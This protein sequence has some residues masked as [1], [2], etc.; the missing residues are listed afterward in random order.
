MTLVSL[1]PCWAVAAAMATSSP[2][3]PQQ[4]GQPP[5]QEQVCDLCQA[6]FSSRNQLFRHLR[7][8]HAD[9]EGIHSFLSSPSPLQVLQS[10]PKERT[11]AALAA[12]STYWGKNPVQDLYYNAQVEAGAFSREEWETA[13]QVFATPLPVT[14]RWLE[15]STTSSVN[16]DIRQEWFHQLQSLV[17]PSSL[18]SS[19]IIDPQTVQIAV[20]PPR[21]WSP[22]AQQVLMDAQEVG[23][24]NRQELCSMIPPFLLLQ[25]DFVTRLKQENKVQQSNTSHSNVHAANRGFAILDLC[26]APGSKSL[27]LLDMMQEQN[28]EHANSAKSTTSAPDNAGLLVCNDA[29]IPRL[30]T[31]ARRSRRQPAYYR[32]SMIL[33]SSDGRFFPALRR[34]GGY[35]HKFDAV[36]VDVPCSGDGTL[37]K[38]SANQWQQWNVQ[39]H[40]A[41]HKLQVKLLQR[42]LQSVTKGGRVVYS[43]CSLDPIENEAVLV[44]AIARMGGP[45]AY[46]I[47]PLPTHL[48]PRSTESLP[49]SKGATTWI[50]P[51]PQFGKTKK[52]KQKTKDL[53]GD[54]DDTT[55]AT[56]TT[57]TTDS[58]SMK[59]PTYET[60]ESIDQVPSQFFQKKTILPSMFPP[61]ARTELVYQKAISSMPIY[62]RNN[63]N[64]DDDDHDEV[65][66][67][68]Q[69]LQQGRFFG[70]I[71][72]DEEMQQFE[73]MLPNCG[74]ILP[75]HLDSGGFFCALIERMPP[76]YYPICCPLQR[77]PQTNTNAPPTISAT[78]QA[79]DGAASTIVCN[80]TMDETPSSISS[81]EQY[82]S[83]SPPTQSNYHGRI[84]FPVESGRQV[85]ELLAKDK[86]QGAEVYFEGVATKDMA[87]QWLQKHRAY[88]PGISEELLAPPPSLTG[89]SDDENDGSDVDAD[90]QDVSM[91][92]KR[93]YINDPNR[94][95]LYTPLFPAPHPNLVAEFME[96]FGLQSDP[97]QAKNLGVDV[98]P[99]HRL[100]VTAGASGEEDA[101]MVET[102]LD[103][104]DA[105]TIVRRDGTIVS[106][107]SIPG[108]DANNGGGEK[109]GTA[110][111]D[112]NNTKDNKLNSSTEKPLRKVHRRRR[113]LQLA[114]VSDHIKTL[115]KGGAKFNPMEVGL[116]LCWVPI[117]GYCRDYT[118]T[119]PRSKS[120]PSLPGGDG[121]AK[122]EDA[123]SRA[124]ES[125][126]FGLL[127]EAAE[128]LGR[129]VTR[130]VVGLTQEEAC[131]LLEISY[132]DIPTGSDRQEEAIP[133][134][135]PRSVTDWRSRWGKQRLADLD[136]WG[137]GATIGVVIGGKVDSAGGESVFP[138]LFLPC[139]LTKAKEKGPCRL[140]LLAEQRLSDCWKRLLKSMTEGG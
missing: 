75:Q 78:P 67:M 41:L 92:V 87:I 130:R 70:E 137:P 55:I 89:K 26:A 121:A 14:F 77:E 128:F 103:S 112:G 91:N 33:N 93:K 90:V 50:V 36:L 124:I 114:L 35:K 116:A 99:V 31:V 40:L 37:R 7:D 11:A 140:E 13:K 74:R 4:Q 123:T 18:Q 54:N 20:Q 47:L 122:F 25:P 80:Q 23:V 115:Y 127:D 29:S 38:M 84:L 51:H 43:T 19:S 27:Q 136:K 133:S 15:S 109:S 125:G 110:I 102:C 57:A 107:D 82:E 10:D 139:V 46:R 34:W 106:P 118:D 62:K 28:Y 126:R 65:H 83:S 60:F 5:Q 30:L 66:I 1:S 73:A 58:S 32:P 132:L 95:T 69:K 135:L 76:V 53:D 9:D 129:C 131:K 61:R 21:Q 100:I 12:R 85:R 16:G 48:S 63:D 113:F 22:Q 17:P 96:F 59:E 52:S 44:T 101:V 119:Q 72:S 117:P 49:Y 39:E 134:S 81:R 98:F 97:K 104:D 120:D 86:A 2:P 24:A 94:S 3:Q 88:L 56:A 111:T 64:D 105:F 68:E 6:A 138:T 71:L 8:A 79:A 45:Q 42:A 108:Y